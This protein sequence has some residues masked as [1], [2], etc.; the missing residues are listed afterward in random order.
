MVKVVTSITIEEWLK[1]ELE[2]EGL[3][4]SDLAN[5]L[6]SAWFRSLKQKGNVVERAIMKTRYIQEF[7]KQFDGF[8]L[9]ETKMLL[10][11]LKGELNE[12]N[13]KIN[14]L[15]QK[16]IDHISENEIEELILSA[17][18]LKD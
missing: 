10:E 18:E 8:S 6:F 13:Y 14:E 7:R 1:E 11:E 9:M 12:L 17:G 3:N 2:H 4:I 16:K 5:T 15:S